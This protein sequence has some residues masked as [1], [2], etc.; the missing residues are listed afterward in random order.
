[1]SKFQLGDLDSC[2]ITVMDFVKPLLLVSFFV[3]AAA[4]ITKRQ[5]PTGLTCNL[6]TFSNS[7]ASFPV[8]EMSGQ[9]VCR[10]S[11]TGFALINP[12]DYVERQDDVFRFLREICDPDCLPYVVD[13]VDVCYKS[14]RMPLAQA[15]ASNGNIQCWR[16]PILND[17]TEVAF[18]CYNTTVLG[19]QCTE[20]C[21]SS[22]NTIRSTLSCCVNN[23]FNTTVFGS[24]LAQLQVASGQLW[25]ACGVE[26]INFCPQPD[27]FAMIDA[28]ERAVSQI[29]LS[30]V[31]LILAVNFI[32]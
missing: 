14:F 4:G 22:I 2:I 16:G 27:E 24:E 9:S 17:G 32:V 28:A 23:V 13:L 11:T 31:S 26:R 20:D 12:E 10:E 21:Q 19:Q 30:T 18:N 7:L 15:C 25:D 8:D 5:L 6:T 29:A 1:M 3:F